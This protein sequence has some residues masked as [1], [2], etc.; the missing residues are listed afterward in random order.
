MSE[1]F[2]QKPDESAKAFAAFST[3]LNLGAQRS[4]E[5]VGRKL[6]KSKALMER[7][8]KRHNWV[9]RVEAHAAHWAALTRWAELEAVREYALDRVQRENAQKESE[10][11]ARCEALA[12]AREAMARFK[13]QPKK[14]GTL[15][16]I[17]RLLELASKLGRLSCDMAT[18]RTETTVEEVRTLSGE[19]QAAIEK[20]YGRPVPAEFV[21]VEATAGKP[22]PLA[23]GGRE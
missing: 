7:W 17:A 20:V 16:G 14:A 12:L 13:A 15:E 5:A 18:D 3:Y 4:L 19:F 1:P 23:E 8:S 9:A 6:G 21:D 11:Q 10:W 22:P 2:E